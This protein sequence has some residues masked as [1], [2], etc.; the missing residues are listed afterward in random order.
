MSVEQVRHRLGVA[1]GVLRE[2]EDPLQKV[3]AGH[4]AA[5]EAPQSLH[6]EIYALRGENRYEATYRV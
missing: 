1:E 5:H 6:Q 3:T 4:Q 2:L